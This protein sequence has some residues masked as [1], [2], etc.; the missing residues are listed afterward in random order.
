MMKKVWLV[1]LAVVLVFGLAVLGCD[2][3]GGGGKPAPT[4]PVGNLDDLWDEMWVDG[5]SKTGITSVDLTDNFQYGTGYQGLIQWKDLLNADIKVNDVYKLE[6]TFTVSRDLEDDLEW[7]IVNTA[8]N[9]AYWDEL[10]R[11]KKV[12]NG[13]DKE[14]GEPGPGEN[15]PDGPV[16]PKGEGFTTTETITYEGRV[17]ITNAGPKASSN[18][19]F[20]TKGEGTKGTEGSGKKGKVTLNFTNFKFTKLE[21]GEAPEGPPPADEGNLGLPTYN[22]GDGDT[23]GAESQ[24][25]WVI[26]GTLYDTIV[27]AGT[28]L[29]VTFKNEIAGSGEIIW[30]DLSSWGWNNTDGILG[31]NGEAVEAKG[32]SVSDDKKTL[33]IDLSK[34]LKNYN[35]ANIGFIDQTAKL[36]KVQLILAYYGGTNKMKG[37]EVVKADLVAAESSGGFNPVTGIGFTG[38][39]SIQEDETLALEANVVPSNATNKTISWTATNGSITNGVFTP[40]AVGDATITMTINNGA[41]A[42]TA[43]TRTV[44]VKVTAPFVM[45]PI[46]MYDDFEGSIDANQKYWVLDVADLEEANYFV[47]M[48]DGSLTG[49]NKDGFGGLKVGWQGNGSPGYVMSTGTSAKGWTDMDRSG[50]CFFFISLADIEDYT[51]ST[52][53]DDV[54]IYIGHWGWADLGAIS[55]L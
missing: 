6:I 4:P 20:Q 19:A 30:Q 44:T 33:T 39:G 40:T 14:E 17:L 43:F 38:K 32:T 35:V 3:G 2:S 25:Q 36:K 52:E 16:T 9:V 11:W 22:K 53:G 31:E 48:T 55:Y 5:A 1:L 12:V 28:K 29:V 24:A 49:V 26:D 15:P 42:S 8:A 23:D 50:V 21:W 18:L 41:T 45:T 54:R 37:L 47:F 46:N 27:T 10:G 51:A 7:V 34:A 13:D